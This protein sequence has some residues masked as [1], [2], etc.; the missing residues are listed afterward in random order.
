MQSLEGT[1]LTALLEAG[2]LVKLK[3]AGRY[4]SMSLVPSPSSN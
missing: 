1:Q 3:E 4:F 2:I